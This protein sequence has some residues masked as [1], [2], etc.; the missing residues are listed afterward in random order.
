MTQHVVAANRYYTRYSGFSVLLVIRGGF[1][2][3]RANS[4]G[5]YASDAEEGKK[6][7]VEL[8]VF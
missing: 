6:P 8:D 7:E 5:I 1:A 2:V 4:T 3:D